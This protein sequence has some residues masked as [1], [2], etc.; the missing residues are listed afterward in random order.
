MQ[1]PD[2]FGILLYNDNETSKIETLDFENETDLGGWTLDNLEIVVILDDQDFGDDFFGRTAVRGTPGS[3]KR[4]G[5]DKN[6]TSESGSDESSN[7]INE[8]EDCKDENSNEEDKSIDRRNENEDESNAELGNRHKSRSQVASTIDEINENV[9]ENND[10]LNESNEN[11]E[12]RNERNDDSAD[13]VYENDS[14]DDGQIVDIN[15]VIVD[16]QQ[17]ENVKAI[18][19]NTRPA[20]FDRFIRSTSAPFDDEDTLTITLSPSK[21]SHS[22]R[23]DATAASTTTI[24]TTTA[25]VDNGTAK[26]TSSVINITVTT[27]SASV[28]GTTTSAAGS[29][30]ASTTTTSPKWTNETE[31]TTSTP[32]PPPQINHGLQPHADDHNGTIQRNI[33]FSVRFCPCFGHKKDLFH[34]NTVRF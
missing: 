10:N 17:S 30:V 21:R 4:S 26:T 15:D 8:K 27:T 33:I 9:H 23:A 6:I 7:E 20:I 25:A 14:K 13:A 16:P 11:A 3:L 2:E 1:A 29:S 34:D 12:E 32:Q 24:T 19:N 5:N 31:S 28:N 22:H 18:P